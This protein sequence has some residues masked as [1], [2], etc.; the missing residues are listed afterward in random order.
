MNYT[1]DIDLYKILEAADIAEN[2][3]VKSVPYISSTS[4][5]S[6]LAGVFSGFSK[7]VDRISKQFGLDPKDL[8]FELGKRKVVAGQEDIII[9]VAN[10]LNN[11]K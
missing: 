6:G 2:S 3:F 4:V 7:Q 10:Q 8:F 9:E 1:T 5:V 11:A